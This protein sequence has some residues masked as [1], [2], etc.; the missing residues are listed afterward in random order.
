MKDS[1]AAIEA[2]P[3][4]PWGAFLCIAFCAL[5]SCLDTQITFS[6]NEF[7]LDA[8]VLGWS[9][10]GPGLLPCL[11]ALALVGVASTRRHLGAR[12][13]GRLAGLAAC[14]CLLRLTS[15]WQPVGTIFP[16]LS[17][18]WSPHASWALAACALAPLM[19][20]LQAATAIA[21]ARRTLTR[22]RIAAALFVLFSAAYCAWALYVSQ[23]STVHGDEVHFL[24]VS[25]SL[26]RDGDIDLH[27][28]GTPEDIA[29]FR[30]LPFE[31]HRAPSSPPGTTYSVHA[32]GLSALLLPAYATGLA[33]WQNPRLA[34]YLFMG[35]VTAA[36]LS[37]LFLWLTRLGFTRA[38]SLLTI[39]IM[40][41]TAPTAFFSVQI[42]PDFPAIFVAAILL[43]LLAH[44]QTGLPRV[45]F[46]RFE[47][48]ILFFLGL[49]L[50]APLLLHPRFLP[51]SIL[52]G[53]LLLLQAHTSQH[54]G[55]AL[56]AVATAVLLCGAAQVGYNIHV[57]GDW[58]GH[59]RPGNAWNEHALQLSTWQRSL[60]GHW[61]HATKGV[62]TNAPIWLL[63][64]VGAGHLLR[65]RDRRLLVAAGLYAATA[66]VNGVH[67]DWSFG[68]GMPARFMVSALPALALLLCAALEYMLRRPVTIFLVAILL[69]MSWDSLLQLIAM[70]IVAYDGKHLF[71][72][73]IA[74][75]YPVTVHLV[76]GEGDTLSVADAI[77]WTGVLVALF[78]L[79]HG[80]RRPWRLVMVLGTAAV[81]PALWGLAPTS[82]SRLTDHVSPFLLTPIADQE[83]YPVRRTLG[84]RAY[85]S[86]TGHQRTDGTWEALRQDHLPGLLTS[87]FLPFQ[88]P[89]VHELSID[90]FFVHGDGAPDHVVFTSRKTLPVVQRWETREYLPVDRAVGKFR[91][92]Y[93]AESYDL[94]Y[95]FF[96]FTGRNDLKVGTLNAAFQPMPLRIDRQELERFDTK[97]LGAKSPMHF[98]VDGGVL[99]RGRYRVRFLLQGS[100]W[101]SLLV[102]HPEPVL[103]AVIAG[104]T[105]D[106]PELRL[107]GHRW[108]LEDRSRGAV[109]SDP[110]SVRPL[111]ERVQA[112][113]WLHIPGGDDAYDLQFNLSQQRRVR[114]LFRYDGPAKL[115]LDEVVLFAE[116]ILE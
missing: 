94:G 14:L 7:S 115:S 85:Q 78:G 26:Q 41:T 43:V 79:G 9:A 53:L 48:A 116:E 76:T 77:L 75:F 51:L 2:G 1:A 105:E 46:G 42:Y 28:N 100:A 101:S 113:W 102:P 108:F 104:K 67:P 65:H 107:L 30:Q 87:N 23:M 34:C 114:L 62:V 80:L 72:Q 68:F 111:V 17:I 15:L 63:T 60:P 97:Y 95:V 24:L 38:H 50:G 86:T 71:M 112:P 82:L 93:L 106:E 54:R 12:G 92:I 44:W 98:G 57:S 20:C 70:P 5:T 109:F 59:M 49:A 66:V 55:L 18:L 6:R 3:Q 52:L 16:F 8:D 64:F 110:N 69:A 22:G 45:D 81:L 47:P 84:L 25:Q 27:N 83:G 73:S 32:P 33:L 58:L 36:V 11:L 96:P 37:L 19:S 35:L 88:Q 61:L 90:S 10:G 99:E 21:F 91:R 29:E 103:T 56:G 31:I 4:R 40:G 74:R 39:G 13:F 89:G